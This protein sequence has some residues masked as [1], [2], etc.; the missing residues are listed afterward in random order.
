[1]RRDRFVWLMSGVVIASAVLIGL[2]LRG[3]SGF[4][5]CLLHRLTGLDC[6]GCGM[7]RAV[8]STL[9]GRIAEAFRFNPLGMLALPLFA[10]WLVLRIPAWLRGDAPPER[11]R[12]GWRLACGLLALVFC[13]GILRN[14]PQWPFSLLGTP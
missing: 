2:Y 7:T 4:P 12:I 9:H 1:M 11:L 6:P 13:Y 8:Q 5:V 10:V 3:P 14:I